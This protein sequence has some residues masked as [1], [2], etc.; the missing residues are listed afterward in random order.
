[1]DTKPNYRFF[2]RDHLL[3]CRPHEQDDGR[4]QARVAIAAMGGMKTR[5]QRFLDLAS[6]DSHDAAVEHA[7]SAGIEWVEK[8]VPSV[9]GF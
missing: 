8:N 3:I 2:H 9:V 5:T 4:F 7:H 1:M 6:F